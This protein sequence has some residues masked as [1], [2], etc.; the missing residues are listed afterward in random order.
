MWTV[1]RLTTESRAYSFES[2]GLGQ[3]ADLALLGDGL[4]L[5]NM[6]DAAN[7]DEDPVQVVVCDHCGCVQCQ[8]GNW[9]SVRRLGEWVVMVA[10]TKGYGSADPFERGEFTPPKWLRTRGAPLVPGAIWDEARAGGAALPRS[11]ALPHLRWAEVLLEAQL[12][13]P[14]RLLGDPG[15]KRD[16]KLS[17][18]VSATDPWV[19]PELL[20]K[21]GELAWDADPRARVIARK[22]SEVETVTLFLEEDLQQEVL[23]GLHQ[24]AVGLYFEPGLVLFPD[25]AYVAEHGERG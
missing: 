11:D 15:Q 2:S 23:L 10:T 8:P 7:W 6:V 22:A 20:D 17:S 5:V 21:V 25:P 14:R 18:V 3:H 24:G 9:V 13:A 19:A 4:E 12:E 1:T 16:R